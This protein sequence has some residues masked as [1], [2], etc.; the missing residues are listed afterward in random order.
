MS[1]GNA[2]TNKPT[3]HKQSIIF[4]SKY[5]EYDVCPSVCLNL[6]ISGTAKPIG[7]YSS[8]NIAT[9]PVGASS[10]FLGG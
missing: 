10:Y 5:N 9:G 2:A 7:L 1:F 4:Y 8:G 6:M 3:T